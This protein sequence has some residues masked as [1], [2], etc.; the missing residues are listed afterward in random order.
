MRDAERS[1]KEGEG[2][3][4]LEQQQRAQRA[5][6]MAQNQ[7]QEDGERE[8]KRDGDGQSP[9]TKDTEIPDKNKH[10]GPEQFRKRVMDGLGGASD[11]ALKKAVKRYA[12]G[13]LR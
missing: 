12:E 6:E 13:L 8:S 5:L 3:R 10:K 4:G 11:P 7:E 9:A 2:D 1:L